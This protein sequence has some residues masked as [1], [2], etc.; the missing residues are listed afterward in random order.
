MLDSESFLSKG[1]KA[2]SVDC[3]RSLIDPKQ[4]EARPA[5]QIDLPPHALN[6]QGREEVIRSLCLTSCL[7]DLE[8]SGAT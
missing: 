5:K 1:M 4:L 7:Q 3:Q 6:E 8:G 2:A